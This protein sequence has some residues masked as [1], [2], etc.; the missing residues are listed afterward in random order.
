[1][2]HIVTYNLR[3]KHRALDDEIQRETRGL[4]PDS[5]RLQ[6]LKRRK[7]ALRDQIAVRE[8]GLAPARF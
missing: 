7:M 8:A 1:M 3:R 5:L 6:T 4:A 2:D